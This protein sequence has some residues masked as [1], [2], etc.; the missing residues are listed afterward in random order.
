MHKVKA[1]IIAYFL[2]VLCGAMTSIGVSVHF[3][4]TGASAGVVSGTLI[5]SACASIFVAPFLAP[6]F[7][8]FSIRTVAIGSII[9]EIVVLV[10]LVLFLRP[11]VLIAGT[12]VSSALAGVSIPAI[13]S[14]TEKLAPDLAAA[15]VFSRLDTAR[16]VGGF[17]GS[18]AGGVVV[19]RVSLSGAFLAEIVVN[20]CV[21]VVLCVV[22]AP[23]V[24]DDEQCQ[25]AGGDQ[26]SFW[27]RLVEAPSLL[28]RHRQARVALQSI[29]VAII[30]TS[31]YNVALVFFALNELHA[32]GL[33][34][35]VLG[36]GFVVGRIVGARLSSRVREG[37]AFVVLIVGGVVMGVAIAGVGV[38]RSVIVGVVCALVAGVCN[39]VQ[40]GA[41]RLLMCGCVR[42]L[43]R[44]W[45]R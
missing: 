8:K 4:T 2:T 16:L 36:Q 26:R 11:V 32:G 18:A 43:C 42:R 20:L 6:V 33:G 34:Y 17:V 1:L 38:G 15:Q 13:F 9:G 45:V 21:I 37:N 39:A 23:R 12:L 24:G 7:D 19:E 31:V 35:A 14:L 27:R 25:G 3:A 10:T 30:F 44:R 5:A 22:G 40:V 29:W 28:L 41:L